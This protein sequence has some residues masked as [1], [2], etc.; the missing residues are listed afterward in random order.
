MSIRFSAPRRAVSACAALLFVLLIAVP[1]VAQAPA[2]AAPVLDDPTAE[3]VALVDGY[4]AI[5]G[6][7]EDAKVAGLE[8]LLAPGFQVVRAN[9]DR[10][11]RA[12]YLASP[13]EVETYAITDAVATQDADVLVVSYLL[14]TSETVDGVAQTTTAPRLTV[15]HWIDDAWLLAAHAN[16]GALASPDA[17]ESADTDG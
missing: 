1:A 5:L 9:G 4:M 15:F 12:G 16:F 13:P 8:T 2:A 10:Q 11:D 3:G 14:E 17:G 6:L 7:P